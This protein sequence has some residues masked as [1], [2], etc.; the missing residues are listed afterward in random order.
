MKSNI[1]TTVIVSFMT[2]A[3]VALCSAYILVRIHDYKINVLEADVRDI[4]KLI[5]GGAE[6]RLDIAEIRVEVRHIKDYIVEQKKNKTGGS[7]TC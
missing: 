4:K 5:Q 6:M 2:A 1:W 7:A 3:V